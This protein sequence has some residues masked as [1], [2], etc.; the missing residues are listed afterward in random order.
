MALQMIWQADV[1]DFDAWHAVFREDREARDHA[2]LSTL[3]VWRDPDSP[4]HAWVL[5]R[6]ND[7]ERAEAFIASEEL[8][9]HR[10][11][12]GIAHVTT[13]FLETA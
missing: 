7:R 13:R 12:A 9:M 6:V 8:A 3:Q 2:G 5:F 10:E 4:N 11:R 1:A